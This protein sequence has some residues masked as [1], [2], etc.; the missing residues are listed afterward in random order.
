MTMKPPK[1]TGAEQL[2]RDHASF[3]ASFLYRLGV[4]DNDIDDVVQQVFVVA[5]QKGGYEEGPAAPRTWLASIAVR[6]AAASRRSTKRLRERQHYDQVA[7]DTAASSAASPEE[8]IQI[9]D[10]I[11]RVQPALDALD[12]DH[13]AAFVLFELEGVPCTDIATAIGVPVG[14]VYSRLHN[15]RRRF[16]TA[17]RNIL[18]N[19]RVQRR[20]T[21]EVA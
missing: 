17:H 14:T 11:W 9:R 3:I 21:P 13:R 2:F 16:E 8:A 20:E 1:K 7:I 19:E 10:S 12:A 6:L 15:A 18:K 4:R 5:H